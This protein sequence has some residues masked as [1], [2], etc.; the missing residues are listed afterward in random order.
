MSLTLAP[1][2]TA[3]LRPVWIGGSGGSA[4]STICMD[5]NASLLSEVTQ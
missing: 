2:H 4:E 1:F 3:R 5:G